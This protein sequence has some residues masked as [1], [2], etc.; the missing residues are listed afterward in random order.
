MRFAARLAGV[1]LLLAGLAGCDKAQIAQLQSQVATIT[2][3]AVGTDAEL[4]N[5]WDVF[6]DADL[7][8]VSDDGMTYLFCEAVPVPVGFPPIMVPASPP[9]NH[10]IRVSILRADATAFEDITDPMYLTPANNLTPY[11]DV[12]LFGNLVAKPNPFPFQT[13]F[14]RFTNPRQ[15][16]TVSREVVLATSNPLTS[17]SPATF[18]YKFGLCSVAAD[19]GPARLAGAPA[20]FVFD[21]GKGETLRIEARK[22]TQPPTG[23]ADPSGNPLT[24]IEPTLIGRL[25]IDGV[26]IT[27]VGGSA[28]SSAQV[29]DG[30]SFFYSSR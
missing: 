25:T 19:P 23:L 10:S 24:F 13:S 8:G 11:D 30:F 18:G 2:I 14:F 6:E 17:L 9:W 21:L 20:P 5:V 16:T 29:G 27:D 3:E 7:D 26:P 1:L 22:A 4:L 28:S 15:M 12:V